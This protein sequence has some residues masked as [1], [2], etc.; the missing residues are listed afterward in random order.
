MKNGWY[1]PNIFIN[2]QIDIGVAR[3]C[4]HDHDIVQ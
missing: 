3:F 2:F 4:L 1:T